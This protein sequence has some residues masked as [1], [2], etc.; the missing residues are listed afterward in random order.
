MKQIRP[1]FLKLS[2]IRKSLFPYRSRVSKLCTPCLKLWYNEHIAAYKL[3]YRNS[4]YNLGQGRLSLIASRR[5]CE[6]G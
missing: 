2:Q 3:K 6:Q 5:D 1:Y 4:V